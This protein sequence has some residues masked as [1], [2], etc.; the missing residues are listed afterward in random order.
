MTKGEVLQVLKRENPPIN[1]KEKYSQ[2]FVVVELKRISRSLGM[3]QGEYHQ[4]GKLEYRGS[5]MV[6]INDLGQPSCWTKLEENQSISYGLSL[7]SREQKV[8]E[9]ILGFFKNSF[10][11]AQI[12]DFIPGLCRKAE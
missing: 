3:I 8:H 10:D 5:L 12:Q 1:A 6:P 11:N 2:L 4:D 7:D 9:K